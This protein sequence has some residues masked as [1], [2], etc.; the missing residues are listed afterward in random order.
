MGTADVTIGGSIIHWP[1]A[2]YKSI[3]HLVVQN[4]MPQEARVERVI[5]TAYHGN[6][7]GPP[8]YKFNHDLDPSK[9][10]VPPLQTTVLD[11][12]LSLDEVFL[13][14]SLDEV[15]KLANEAYNRTLYVGVR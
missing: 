14:D 1:P 6:L 15:W 3:L 13:P 5:C 9:Y 12:E 11:I 2:L 7:S 4:P 10:I 8:L